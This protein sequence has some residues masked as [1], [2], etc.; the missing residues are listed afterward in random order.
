MPSQKTV[1]QDIIL[2][3]LTFGVAFSFR[4][5]LIALI[6]FLMPSAEQHKILFLAFITLIMLVMT[7]VLANYWK[8]PLEQ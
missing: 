3:V 2:T 8:H 5:F 1:V 7:L 6:N 4:E